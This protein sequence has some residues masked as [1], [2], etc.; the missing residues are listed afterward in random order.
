MRQLRNPRLNMPIYSENLISD[1]QITAI[2]QKLKQSGFTIDQVE[3]QAIAKG[4]SDLSDKAKHILQLRFWDNMTYEQIASEM[5]VSRERIRQ[6][7]AKALRQ[8][9]H[10]TRSDPL[11]PFV[12]MAEAGSPAQ[13]AAIAISKKE[14]QTDEDQRL[15]PKCWKGYRKAGT[16]MKGGTR[17]NN[18]VPVREDIEDLM[19]G[20][21]KLLG[22]K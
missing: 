12:Q 2:Q 16:K 14:K 3:P 6:I 17:V 19:V 18:C 20:Y 8:L 15:D 7:E 21:I 13:Q 9:K 10:P 11:R 4:M 1:N 5:G 22:N